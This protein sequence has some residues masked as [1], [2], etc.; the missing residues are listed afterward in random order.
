MDDD[1]DV[2][3]GEGDALM[4]GDHAAG[5]GARS[6]HASMRS[7]S[8]DS[9][10]VE[11]TRVSTYVGG[12]TELMRNM[13]MQDIYRYWSTLRDWLSDVPRLAQEMSY[14]LPPGITGMIGVKGP[15]MTPDQQQALE[16]F[17]EAN[18]GIPYTHEEHWDMLVKLWKLSFPES[19]GHSGEVPE[20]HDPLWKRLGFQGTDPATDFRAAGTLSV[21]GLLH[22]AEVGD[23]HG[24]LARF[25][26]LSFSAHVALVVVLLLKIF[27]GRW[28][29]HC[30]E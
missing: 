5:I 4:G 12:L 20:Q 3:A 24:T 18:V 22:F 28:R 14:G 21:K 13:D 15:P 16:E 19:D 30:T 17:T 2:V 1:D 10:P 6:S 7:S 8:G 23:P 9:A 11:C 25:T 26:V 29:R 27:T